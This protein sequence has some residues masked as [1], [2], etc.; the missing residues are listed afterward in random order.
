MPERPH[1]EQLEQ[2]T[3]RWLRWGL[4]LIALAVLAFPAYRLYEPANRESS[5]ENL[6][7]SLASQGEQWP[8]LPWRFCSATPIVL[9]APPTRT[10]H[11][12]CHQI[13]LRNLELSP[14]TP[15]QSTPAMQK[16]T[17]RII[18]SLPY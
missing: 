16:P 12:S 11:A 13:C 2:S 1:D 10:L 18:F 6:L 7:A 4:I 3:N 17:R 9:Y 8:S 15:T 14:N 5:R